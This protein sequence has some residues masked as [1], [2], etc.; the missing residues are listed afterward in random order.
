MFSSAR[1]RWWWKEPLSPMSALR[2]LIYILIYLQFSTVRRAQNTKQNRT[3]II[4]VMI[5]GFVVCV[6]CASHSRQKRF[7]RKTIQRMCA[8]IGRLIV[9]FIVRENFH[10]EI[11]CHAFGKYCKYEM[12][13]CVCVVGVTVAC[14]CRRIFVDW[15]MAAAAHC[16]WMRILWHAQ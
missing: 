9:T 3:P 13:V 7:V 4:M 5:C 8:N 16:I 2:L 10:R 15:R 12:C 6:V 14:L 11:E 1:L